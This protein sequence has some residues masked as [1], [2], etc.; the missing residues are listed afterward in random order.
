MAT[1]INN[2]YT[3]N[4]APINPQKFQGMV[5]SLMPRAFRYSSFEPFTTSELECGVFVTG[6]SNAVGVFNVSKPTAAASKIFGVTL[7]ENGL[8]N[9]G[10]SEDLNAYTY[11]EDS[12]VSLLVEGDIVMYSET[13]VEVGDAVYFRHTADALLTRVGAVANAAGTGLE[14]VPGCKFLDTTTAPGLVRVSIA[15]II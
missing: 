2:Q 1:G 14:A 15:D 13:A 12:Q 5:I 4:T 3:V 8:H 10:Y 11:L 6:E 9:Y 7:W